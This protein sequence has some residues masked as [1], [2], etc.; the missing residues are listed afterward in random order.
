MTTRVKEGIIFEQSFFP[1]K[2]ENYNRT[3]QRQWGNGKKVSFKNIEDAEHVIW[4]EVSNVL[5]LVSRQSKR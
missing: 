2:Q 4:A 1:R 3:K 5:A